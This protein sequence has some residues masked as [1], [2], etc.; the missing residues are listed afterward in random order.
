NH[1]GRQIK[2]CDAIAHPREKRARPSR[3]AADIQ[4]ARAFRQIQRFQRRRKIAQQSRRLGGTRAAKRFFIQPHAVQAAGFLDVINFV[5]FG[6]ES[7]IR[8][9]LSV[10][11]NRF[12]ISNSAREH[13]KR[14]Q[15]SQ[16]DDENIERQ[17][18][19]GTQGK[20]DTAL[21][22][23]KFQ[24]RNIQQKK[25]NEQNKRGRREPDVWQNN[26]GER[27]Q[28]SQIN[29][30]HGELIKQRHARKERRAALAQPHQGQCP[31]AFEIFA[32]NTAGRVRFEMRHA[33]IGFQTQARALSPRALS[34][35]GIFGN[36]RAA[37]LFVKSAEPYENAAPHRRRAGVK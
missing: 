5:L 34:K 14:R 2:T 31:R 8:N 15:H 36:A 30:R 21:L 26:G 35:F 4:H 27:A 19:R 11:R 17:K 28:H 12:S 7:V 3:T 16:T 32:Q 10:S 20:A 29:R 24:Q 1:I 22:R 25:N 6:H 18:E 9:Q 37:I 33:Q 23:Q 13:K